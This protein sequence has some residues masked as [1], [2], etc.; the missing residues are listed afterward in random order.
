MA[1]AAA[2]V[3][4]AVMQRRLARRGQTC[5]RAKPVAEPGLPLAVLIAAAPW[6]EDIALRVAAYLEKLGAAR[7]AGEDPLWT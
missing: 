5:R 1:V 3:A 7:A 2:L 4:G 6:R